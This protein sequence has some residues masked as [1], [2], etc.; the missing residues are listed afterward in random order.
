[1][2]ECSKVCNHVHIPLQ[3]GSDG[4][5][6]A[7]RR[8]YDMKRYYEIVAEVRET[9]PRVA[10]TTDIITGYVGETE[11]DFQATLEAMRRI[12]FDHAYMFSY[13]PREGTPAFGQEES[14]TPEEKQSR[15]EQVIEL[16]M[17]I[18]E[19]KLDSLLGLDFSILLEG[20]SPRNPEEWIGKT[21]CFRKAVVSK[22]VDAL[23]G[24]T[25]RARITG[26]KGLVLR[27]EACES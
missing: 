27:A 5:L 21:T 11:E 23:P 20:P 16:Q 8:Q 13:S 3:S 25:V 22:P 9:I 19:A 15:L 4:L 14:L 17:S 7:M 10:L 6:K 18:T 26:R 24:L 12:Q 2:A 1:M